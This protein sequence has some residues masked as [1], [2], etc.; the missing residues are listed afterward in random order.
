[1]SLEQMPQELESW[2]QERSDRIVDLIGA[3]Q[4]DGKVL[5]LTCQVI[6]RLGRAC[7]T[8]VDA[9]SLRGFP[10]ICKSSQDA[11]ADGLP[12]DV[13]ASLLFNY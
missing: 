4:R 8:A 12:A 6:G 11:T 3:Y 7:L 1:M 9:R 2:S 13:N 10:T 5:W